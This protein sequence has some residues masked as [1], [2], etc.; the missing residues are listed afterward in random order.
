VNTPHGGAAFAAYRPVKRPHEY[1][2]AKD[3]YRE[4]DG[5]GSDAEIWSALGMVPSQEWLELKVA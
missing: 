1:D 2:E 3:P 5:M 4:R